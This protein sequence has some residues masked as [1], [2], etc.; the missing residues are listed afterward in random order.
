MRRAER[1]ARNEL[2]QRRLLY[3]SVPRRRARRVPVRET[4]HSQ[5]MATHTQT[6]SDGRV[7][8]NFIHK[9]TP[10]G[11]LVAAAMWLSARTAALAAMA[12]TACGAPAAGVSASPEVT[13]RV[14]LPRADGAQR[15]D[16]PPCTFV[17]IAPAVGGGNGTQ[18]TERTEYAFSLGR[19]GVHDTGFSAPFLRADV[20]GNVAASGQGDAPQGEVGGEPSRFF[21]QVRSITR[22]VA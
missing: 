1:R 17:Y 2:L 12:L 3:F 16:V 8:R 20:A 22:C 19:G 7:K 15:P 4:M 13:A 11:R 10:R 18:G 9:S 6:H 21:Y 14:A 5:S